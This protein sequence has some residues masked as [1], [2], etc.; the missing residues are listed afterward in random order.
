MAKEHFFNGVS[1]LEKERFEDAEQ[2]FIKSL[3]FLPDRAST[4]TNLSAAQFKLNKYAEA[5]ISAK[6]AIALDPNNGQGFLNLGL[7]EK[8]SDNLELA[9]NLFDKAITLEPTLSEAYLNQGAALNEMYRNEE[10]ISSL[11]KAISLQP[12]YAEAYS[13]KGNALLELNRYDE[14]ISLFD[15]AISLQPNYAEA[16]SNKGNALL[17]L[18]RYDEAISLFDKA[19]SL[20]PNQVYAH[21]NKSLALLHIN[22]HELAWPLYE[23]RWKTKSQK[24]FQRHYSEPQWSGKE[25]LYG[26]KILVWCEQGFGDTIQFSRYIKMIADLG[27][28]VIFQTPKEL[29]NCLGSLAGVSQIVENGA[30]LPAFDLHTPLLS[31]PLAFNTHTKTIPS[32][33]PYIFPN[34]EQVIAW[35][36]KINNQENL[37]VGLVWSSGARIDH[38]AKRKSIPLSTFAK[39]KIPGVDLYSLQ[40]GF[41]AENELISLNNESW[42]EPKIIN[43]SSQINDFSDTAALIANLDLIISVDTSVAH[44]AGAIGKPVWILSRHAIDWRWVPEQQKL[45]YPNATVFRQ[46]FDG[47]WEGVIAT[48]KDLLMNLVNRHKSESEN[49]LFLHKVLK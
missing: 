28:N 15:K 7:I 43:F 19:I 16:Y 35:N 4:L 24:K 32:N 39:F 36:A 3:E 47:D 22:Q 13:N 23:W 46:A 48:A 34:P 1:L 18:N 5:R 11:N 45:W 27:G 12:N 41:E 33:I 2:E 31:L 30:T 6:K 40:K 49:N 14:A 8:E 29:T 20:N 44:L 21:W 25:S 38:F 9:I 37:K 17:E 42:F 26:K 10:A